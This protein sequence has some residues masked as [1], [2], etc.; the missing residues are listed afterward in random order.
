MKTLKINIHMAA[1][2]GGQFGFDGDIGDE[3]LNKVKF[4]ISKDN[5]VTL[6][7]FDFAIK[8]LRNTFF[9]NIEPQKWKNS[10]LNQFKRSHSSLQF[11]GDLLVKNGKEGNIV[12][13]ISFTFL[14]EVLHK[15]H[16]QLAH[17]M[18]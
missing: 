6:Q 9:N 7:K 5:L 10:C 2:Y 14:V 17:I 16:T 11:I 8:Q 18:P 12:P 15:V 4:S 3:R 13:V 1:Y